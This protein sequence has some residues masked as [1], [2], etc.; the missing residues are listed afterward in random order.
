MKII[1][2]VIL[3]V[4][5]AG[6]AAGL[7]PLGDAR[8][9]DDYAADTTTTGRVVVG[10]SSTGEIETAGDQDWF[11]VR[12][13]AG[14][15]YRFEV[16]DTLF[17]P[18]LRGLYKANGIFI[19]GTQDAHHDGEVVFWAK[20][21]GTHYVAVSASPPDNED[22][23]GAYTL[24]VQDVTPPVSVRQSWTD[25][26]PGDLAAD[27]RT[28]GRIG[29][30]V[31]LS[32][33]FC[34]ER[35]SSDQM[36]CRACADKPA[37]EQGACYDAVGLLDWPDDPRTVTEG[38]IDFH[39]DR[40]WYAVEM[41]S[42]HR[43]QVDIL[44]E[45][46]GLGTLS[47]T[48]LHGIYDEYGQYLEHTYD[49]DGGGGNDAQL[50]FTPPADGTYYIS[51]GGSSGRTGTYAVSV[52]DLGFA[53]AISEPE[54][55]DFPGDT[56][57]QGLIYPGGGS[58]TGKV[59]DDDCGADST[60]TDG[61]AYYDQTNDEFTFTTAQFEDETIRD[62][63]WFAI[64]LQAGIRYRFV[65]D[66]PDDTDGPND[67]YLTLYNSNG[68][69][70]DAA[71]GSC[72]I[73]NA[74]DDCVYA[75]SGS[76]VVFTPDKDGTYYISVQSLPVYPLGGVSSALD[77]PGDYYTV[78]VGIH[79][80]PTASTN[81]PAD[82][83]FSDSSPGAGRGFIF[84]GDS[85]TGTINDITDRDAFSVRLES[86]KKYQ[87]D[88]QGKPSSK[89]TLEDPYIAGVY[90][91]LVGI[92]GSGDDDSGTDDEARL[93]CLQPTEDGD[94]VIVFG[95]ADAKTGTYTATVTDVSD[96]D[97]EADECIPQS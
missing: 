10:G 31:Q 34:H 3:L 35:P 84:V 9:A 37:G 29:K 91:D 79:P 36:M 14:R 16:D 81:E 12:L 76:A 54:G 65:I 11:A 94:Y 24:S 33:L 5:F 40:D 13:T 53:A 42:S 19:T 49:N 67:V 78:W 83:D 6:V 71:K 55:K 61:C 39:G 18:W 47:N 45:D 2:K 44:G 82:D 89:G 60:E 80:Y 28:T 50:I 68:D 51:V 20:T 41:D 21:S 62:V 25:T 30:V 48:L 15:A 56:T 26:P 73:Y 1:R 86:G 85:V 69:Q 74:D 72:L 90:K 52:I 59:N 22:S 8:A 27:R 88:M 93:T 57:T 92:R 95:S 64:S 87:I 75:G 7:M 96:Q 46:L 58:A 17:T 43:Y 63:D 23:T 77:A 70:I 66:E 38:E 97:H 4:L 32:E